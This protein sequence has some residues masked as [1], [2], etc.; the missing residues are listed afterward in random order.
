VVLSYELRPQLRAIDAAHCFVLRT[1]ADSLRRFL[2]TVVIKGVSDLAID[3][4]PP[5]KFSGNSLRCRK[6]H[7]LYHGTMLYDY[8]LDAIAACLRTPPRQPDYREGRDHQGFVTNL[9]I[10]RHDVHAAL[11]QAFDPT[12]GRADWPRELTAELTTTRYAQDEW[13]RMR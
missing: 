1:I 8:P 10:A 7:M 9:P 11:T 4:D 6:S 5:R 12:D 2:P 3:D 13:N